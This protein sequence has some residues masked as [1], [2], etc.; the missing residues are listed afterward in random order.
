MGE[1]K[2]G[3]YTKDDCPLCRG[4]GWQE[5]SCIG[6]RKRGCDGCVLDFYNPRKDFDRELRCKQCQLNYLK[7]M[8]EKRECY[9]DRGKARYQCNDCNQGICWSCR[10]SRNGFGT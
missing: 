5:K 4:S 2:D 10:T 8:C 9:R 7:N 6:C 3:K 1:V